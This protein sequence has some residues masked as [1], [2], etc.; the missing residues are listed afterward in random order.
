MQ[1]VKATTSINTPTGIQPEIWTGIMRWV[2]KKASGTLEKKISEGMRIYNMVMADADF[3]ATHQAL[4]QSGLLAS[5]FASLA[6]AL[7]NETENLLDN[8]NI[9]AAIQRLEL[10]RTFGGETAD[11]MALGAR[12][13]LEMREYRKALNWSEAAIQADEKNPELYCLRAR[14]Y[15]CLDCDEAAQDDLNFALLLNPD[16]AEALILRGMMWQVL[17]ETR[18]AIADLR[19]AVR[20]D[21]GNEEAWLALGNAYY[22]QVKLAEAYTALREVLKLNPFDRQALYLCGMI[23]VKLKLEL[24]TARHQLEMSAALGHFKARQVLGA[25]F[26]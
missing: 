5:D 2:E 14:C 9:A 26:M 6:K 19:R 4:F 24:K 7:K 20:I 15:S 16:C 10:L 21:T 11:N 3:L 12:V 18:K 13:Y 17:G 23:R 22:D 25:H 1:Q 8:H